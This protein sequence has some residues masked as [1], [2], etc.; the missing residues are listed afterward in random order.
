MPK[1]V[2]VIGDACIDIHLHL[3][4][5]VHS[6]ESIPY[7]TCLGGTACASAVMLAGLGADTAFLGTVGNDYG[8]DYIKKNLSEFGV[9]TGMMI[10]DDRLNTM[11][12]FSFID[13]NGERILWGFPRE[14]VAYSEL[15]LSQ[16]DIEKIKES[17]WI[18]S[19]GMSLLSGGS[20][21]ETLPEIYEIA[22]EFGVITSFDF[23]TRVADIKL[24]KPEAV[25]AINKIIPHVDYL[26]G[27]A[28]DE[29]SS[30]YPGDDYKYS[31]RY[32]AKI[33]KAV[34]ARSGKEKTFVVSGEK[35]KTVAVYDVEAKNTT[36]AGDAF[37]AGFIVG[38]LEGRDVFEATKLANAAAAIK[39]SAEE[40][41]YSIDRK[42][43]DDFM[44]KSTLRI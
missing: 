8:G 19:S 1:K 13:E 31:A 42:V 30:F 11:N 36:G 23:N 33:C 16:T 35:E 40:A 10:T 2:V 4:D 9:D 25:E 34:I 37:N 22:H 24:L 20:I 18:H 15:K 14:D 44:S 21:I 3:H 32:F 7:K 27:S 26:F 43:L 29:I 41:S 5:L 12:V 6:S 17:I 28:K 38:M 39:I